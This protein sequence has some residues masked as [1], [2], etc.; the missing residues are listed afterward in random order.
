L[1]PGHRETGDRS[2]CA[3]NLDNAGVDNQPDVPVV[4]KTD[5]LL[6]IGEVAERVDLSL[7]SVRFYEEEGLLSPEARSTGGFRLYT[8][9]QVERLLLIKRMK[10]LGFKVEQMRE[11]LSASDLLS[12][13]DAL[14]VDREAARRK[15][16]EYSVLAAERCEELRTQLARAEEFAARLLAESTKIPE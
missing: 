1:T 12:D 14:K 2:P 13:A 7:R 3:G 9:E 10:P 8:E 15:V 5:G 4:K 11:L 6:Q 16:R